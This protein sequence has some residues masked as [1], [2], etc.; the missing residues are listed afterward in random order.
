MVDT[1]IFRKDNASIKQLSSPLLSSP[2]YPTTSSEYVACIKNS[3]VSCPFFLF[4]FLFLLHLEGAPGTGKTLLAR[5]ISR[6]LNA[7]DVKVV[8]GPELLDKFVGEAE[9]NMRLLFKDAE[10]E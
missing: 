6:V 2:F 3:S 4:L 7:R 8:N 9:R 5:E 1:Y 10:D